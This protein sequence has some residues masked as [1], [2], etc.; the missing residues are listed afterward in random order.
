[1]LSTKIN[2]SSIFS[3]ML[4]YIISRFYIKWHSPHHLTN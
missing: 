4:A 2:G 3:K 1:L